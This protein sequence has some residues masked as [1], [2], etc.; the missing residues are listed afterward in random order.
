[1]KRVI[2]G[3][4]FFIFIGVVITVLTVLL[5]YF[6]F[7]PSNYNASLIDFFLEFFQQDLIIIFFIWGILTILFILAYFK[8]KASD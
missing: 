6:F 7:R 1:M 3:I 8:I 2:K 4:L 5:H